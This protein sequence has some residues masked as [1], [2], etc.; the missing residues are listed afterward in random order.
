MRS[1]SPLQTIT[2][3]F[4]GCILITSCYPANPKISDLPAEVKSLEPTQPQVLTDIIEN[5]STPSPTP[6]T[7]FTA[8]PPEPTP[9][10]TMTPTPRW[11]YNAPGSIYAPILLYHRINGEISSGRYEVSEPDF[12]SQML[13]LKEMG[14]TVITMS[15]FL[16]A[17]NDGAELPEKPIVITFDDGHQSVY[18][19]AF[20]I[21][22]A[23]GFPGV[24][25]IVANRINGSPEFVNISQLK[26]MIDADWEIGSHSYTHSDLT[27]DHGI[28]EEEIR[29][30]K[31]DLEY[32]LATKVSTFAYPFGTI[33]PFVA[34]KVNDFGYQAGMG[35]GKSK[36]HTWNTIFYLSRIEIYGT[37]SLDD[38]KMIL[39]EE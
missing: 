18:E 23:L 10:I 5:T 37:Y 29:Q 31:L 27:L 25:Y 1:V 9:T 35:L 33:D 13:A 19:K 15:L 7:T 26:E 12:H 6:T 32:D 38:F 24:F 28:A 8:T 11:V 4:I 3:I 21:M 30:S 39:N 16:Q 20:P 22:K 2:I 14:Y 17:L 34:Q 36:T